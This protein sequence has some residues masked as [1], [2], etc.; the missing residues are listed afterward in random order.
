MSATRMMTTDCTILRREEG[1][2]EEFG[3][4]AGP[5][6]EVKS[7]CALQQRRR[8]EHDEGG[9]LSDTLWDLLLPSGTTIGTGD[10]VRVEGREYELVGEPWDAQEGSRSLWH[11]A[12]TVRRTAGTGE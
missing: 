11:V 9:E 10:S 5:P 6:E 2:E 7:R 3:K 8:S 1:E 4:P 12:A